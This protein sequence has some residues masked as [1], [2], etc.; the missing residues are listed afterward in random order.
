MKRASVDVDETNCVGGGASAPSADGTIRREMKQ[1]ARLTWPIVLQMGSQQIMLACDLIY[2]GRLGRFEMTVGS[3][4]T[5]LFLLCWYFLAGLTSA[6]DTL[7]SQAHGANDPRAVKSWTI[8]V[9][10]VVTV[11]CFPAAAFLFSSEAIVRDVLKRPDAVAREVGRACVILFP[12]LWFMSWSL[13]YQKYLQ[14]QGRVNPV[15]ITSFMTLMLNIGLNQLFIH[16]LDFGLRGAP[17]A[18][19][20]SRL[21]N[22]I[23]LGAYSAS[24]SLAYET[25]ENRKKEFEEWMHAKKNITKKMFQRAGSL[26]FHGGVMLAAE[27]W[28]FEA[29]VITASMLGEVELDAHNALLSVCGLTFMTGPMA[30]GIAANIRVGNLLGMGKHQVAKTAANLYISV[31]LTWM[32]IC[33]VLIAVFARDIGNVYTDGDKDIAD[34]VVVLAPLASTFQVF[35][36]LLGICNGVL[37]ACGRQKILAITNMISLWAIGVTLGTSLAFA[38]SLRTKGIWIGL[39]SGVIFSGTTLAVM[40]SRVKW[41]DEAELAKESAVNVHNTDEQEDGAVAAV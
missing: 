1:L 41:Q 23:L 8:V 4:F 21:A 29:T 24:S 36:A 10:L 11:A 14:M 26:S 38:T 13:V 37:R 34:L 9:L 6:M 33:S 16:T 27:A 28:A 35:D 17:I 39:M 15:G 3:L 22:L 40:V 5:V 30:F 12:G 18:T 2:V 20:I 25:S 32:T 19:T 31:G 7:A